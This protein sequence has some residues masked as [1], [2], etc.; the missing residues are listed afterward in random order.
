[1]LEDNSPKTNNQNK[2]G[3]EGSHVPISDVVGAFKKIQDSINGAID[4][5]A[6]A[7]AQPES[8]YG[9]GAT[10]SGSHGVS[11]FDVHNLTSVNTSTAQKVSCNGKRTCLNCP[12]AKL[13]GNVAFKAGPQGKEAVSARGDEKITIKCERRPEL[14]RFE[15]TI[16][17]EQC[18]EWQSTPYGYLLKNMR[19]MILGLDGYLG[20]PLGLKLASLG[21]QVSGI[22]NYCRRNCSGERGAHSIVPI[23][24]MTERLRAVNEIHN[25]ILNFRW[26]DIRDRQKLRDFLEEEKPEAI[27][28]YAEIPSAP[29]S[30]IGVENAVKVQDNNVLGTLGLL[31][32]IK[33]I[34]PNT[35]LIKLGTMGEYGSPLT[36]RPL[37]EGVF[38]PD[39]ILKWKGKE[40]S[41]GGEITPRD[42]VSFYHISKIQDTF[43]VFQACKY[44]NLRSYDVMQGIIYGVHTDQVAADSRLRT[45]FDIDE[46]FGTVVNRFVSQAIVGVPLTVHGQGEQIKGMIALDD[47]MECMVRL[48]ASPPEPGQYTVVNQV[49]GLHKLKEV[50]DIVAGVARNKF[51]LTPKIQRIENPRQ[52]AE[53]HP[54]EVVSA[55]L[56]SL[57]F[58]PKI[59]LEDEITRMF[60]LLTQPEIVQRIKEKSHVILPR[61]RWTGEKRQSEVLEV[62]EPGTKKRDGHEGVLGR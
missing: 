4:S 57:G 55:N 24:K 47:A 37:F 12:A 21:C 31:W 39:A 22:D 44:W 53:N 9:Q 18:P 19:V 20:W 59:A 34:V 27:V 17:F 25:H 26:M 52:E 51:G 50:A 38:P 6:S 35:S 8:D 13:K 48:I 32:L 49:S 61:T 7:Q 11:G 29:Y 40:W 33:E 58:E 30:M 16:T 2:R 3:E 54:L 15:P 10:A 45:R 46:W 43:N 56:P 60:E 23:P 14:G 41:L 62:Y 5:L 36:G 42:P 1:M 28:H